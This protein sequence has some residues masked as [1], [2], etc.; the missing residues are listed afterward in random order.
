[1]I[2][3]RSLLKRRVRVDHLVNAIEKAADKLAEEGNPGGSMALNALGAALCEE[4]TDKVE[5]RQ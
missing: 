5:K 1:M 3:D 2:K 4:M